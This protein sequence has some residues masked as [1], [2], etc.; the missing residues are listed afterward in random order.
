MV[1]TSTSRSTPRGS[2]SVRRMPA[3]A[4]FFFSVFAHAGVIAHSSPPVFTATL[5]PD[6][7]PVTVR[8]PP[9]DLVGTWRGSNAH[10]V[11]V[12]IVLLG[13]PLP[14]RELTVPERAA[15][16]RSD[17]RGMD[18]ADT[19]GHARTLGFTVESLVGHAHTA[20]GDAVRFSSPV[21]TCPDGILV[22]VLAPANDEAKARGVFAAVLGSVR[23][24]TPWRT[25]GEKRWMSVGTIAG[26]LALGL[27]LAYGLWVFGLRRS[28]ARRPSLRAAVLSVIALCWA[29]MSVGTLAR[30]ER[31]VAATVLLGCIALATALAAITLAG[32]KPSP[33][34]AAQRPA[35]DGSG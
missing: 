11:V 17:P 9:D 29:V 16:R 32:A 21:P 34:T 10:P 26:R 4:I 18:F 5:P 19:L 2:L 23:A 14:Q 31:P 24:R 15:L 12:Q 7:E 33:E 25:V 20:G 1:L 8:E 6:F 3:L 35:P 30:P 28:S 27:S 13:A 22:T